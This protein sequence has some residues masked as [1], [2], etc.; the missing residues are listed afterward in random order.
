MNKVFQITIIAVSICTTILWLKYEN[1]PPK[2]KN[3]P[4]D[5]RSIAFFGD[6]YGTYP[7]SE[8]G[9][10]THPHETN[11]SIRVRY[12]GGS[13]QLIEKAINTLSHQLDDPKP[14]LIIVSL[15][16]ADLNKRAPLEDTLRQLK[17][18][19][20]VIQSQGIM[21]CY[22]SIVPVGLGDNW[23]LAMESLSNQL[24][25]WFIPFSRE[26]LFE[27]NQLDK[28]STLVLNKN[29]ANLFS[30]FIGDKIRSR[31]KVSLYFNPI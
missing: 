21:V 16:L 11:K 26:G 5:L 13:G 12:L 25:V 22:S 30:E 17:K 2:E 8:K 10:P 3:Y 28:D 31:F 29:G 14:D 7:T 24:G 18:L 27:E 9:T 6:G 4:K 20:S 1:T 23:N 19:F 15:G